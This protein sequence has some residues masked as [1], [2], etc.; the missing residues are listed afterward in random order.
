MVR[1]VTGIAHTGNFNLLLR[2]TKPSQSHSLSGL[3][4]LPGGGGESG[5]LRMYAGDQRGQIEGTSGEGNKKKRKRKRRKI[6][7]ERK[8]GEGAVGVEGREAYQQDGPAAKAVGDSFLDS[9][10]D[11][12]R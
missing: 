8:R 12:V 7:K 4:E 9:E 11:Q 10:R 1:R 6:E 2:K 5:W 3:S